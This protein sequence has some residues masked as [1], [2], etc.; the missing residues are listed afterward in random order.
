MVVVKVV[1][2]SPVIVDTDEYTVLNEI[3]YNSF[4]TVYSSV[5]TITGLMSTTFTTSH[6]NLLKT[7]RL[8]G[9]YDEVLH[10]PRKT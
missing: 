9:I 8:V 10:P 2:I 3:W 4:N 5:S 6:E 7:S 1:D